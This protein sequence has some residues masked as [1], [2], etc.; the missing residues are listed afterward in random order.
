M[1][2]NKDIAESN[3]KKN[4]K[5]LANSLEKHRAYICEFEKY[6]EEEKTYV[7]SEEKTGCMPENRNYVTNIFKNISLLDSFET[8]SREKYV[9]SSVVPK[10]EPLCEN[11]RVTYLKNTFSDEAYS[12][13]SSCMEKSRV[14]YSDSFTEVCES[15]YY[16]R[17]DTCIL[18]LENSDEGYLSGFYGLIRKYEL[19]IVL[20]CNIEDKD[21]HFTKFALLSKKLMNAMLPQKKTGERFFKISF[22]PFSESIVCDIIYCAE[23]FGEALNKIDSRPVYYSENGYV[24]DITFSGEGDIGKI[25]SWLDRREIGYEINGIYRHIKK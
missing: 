13:F 18:P 6:A 17:S 2:K 15:V 4:E 7:L 1:I 20:T 23:Y 19:K 22:G 16:N 10:E 11:I 24:F 8:V 3:L 25:V 5:N 21:G 9:N 14:Y 12:I